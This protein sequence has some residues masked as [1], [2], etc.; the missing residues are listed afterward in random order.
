MA[1]RRNSCGSISVTT[2][3]AFQAA[4]ASRSS[5]RSRAQGPPIAWRSCLPGAKVMPIEPRPGPA[6]TASIHS[7]CVSLVLIMRRNNLQLHRAAAPES[8]PFRLRSAVNSGTRS[9]ALRVDWPVYPRRADHNTVA[10][11]RNRRWARDCASERAPIALAESRSE[12]LRPKAS[13]EIDVD[14][15]PSASA[16][17]PRA[18]S[19]A[20]RKRFPPGNPVSTR[21]IRL[22]EHRPGISRKL[23][24]ERRRHRTLRVPLRA[25]SASRSACGTAL[26][27]TLQAFWCSTMAVEFR[28]VFPSVRASFGRPGP[29]ARA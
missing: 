23:S 29:S 16:Q 12:A 14:A 3:L 17:P 6:S 28:S 9:A 22:A 15:A 8:S 19:G 2:A 13:A 4:I 5:V 24:C 25:R 26:I 1:S 21:R 20:G 27:N 10:E 18:A 11:R 7:G